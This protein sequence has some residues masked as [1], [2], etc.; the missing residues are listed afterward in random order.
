MENQLQIQGNSPKQLDG[1][2]PQQLVA[3]I[4][5]VSAQYEREVPG[6]RRHWP[7]SIRCRVHALLRLGV[8]PSKIADL[9]DIPRATVF[10]WSRKVPGRTRAPRRTVAPSGFIQVNDRPTV[11]PAP[12]SPTVGLEGPAALVTPDGFRI[13]FSGADA[14]R[15]ACTVY[16]ELRAAQ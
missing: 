10:L 5:Q 12:V 4:Q 9:T 13:E 2:T 6:G 16:R 3:E 14:W 15:T 8:A 11:R 7:E 1:L